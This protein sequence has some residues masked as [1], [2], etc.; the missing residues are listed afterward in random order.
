MKIPGPLLDPALADERVRRLRALRPEGVLIGICG[1]AHA[2]TGLIAGCEVWYSVIAGTL[3]E[4][5]LALSRAARSGE[6]A[7]AVQRSERLR[8]LWDLFA[9]HGSL[10]VVAAIA[11]QLALVSAKCLPR[12]IQGLGPAD[13]ARAARCWQSSA[14]VDRHRARRARIRAAE[15]GSR[16]R[17]VR[18]MVGAC[19][20]DPP[21]SCARGDARQDLDRR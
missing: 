20:C 3:P 5:A 17:C 14:F 16:R 9:S 4:P 15:I 18:R 2:A 1:D 6:A 21:L 19:G 8:P 13:R 10:R 12:P 7:E 11:E